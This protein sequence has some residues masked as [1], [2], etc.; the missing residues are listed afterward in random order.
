M[1]KKMQITKYLSISFALLMLTACSHR[2]I[3]ENIQINNRLDCLKL[4]PAQVDE[5]MK[6]YSK[7][8]DEY[9]KERKEMSKDLQSN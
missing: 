2:D 8:Y 4:P 5:C 7:S 6:V 1:R 3:Y 9:E